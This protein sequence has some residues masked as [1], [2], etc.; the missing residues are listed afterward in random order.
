MKEALL[1]LALAVLAVTLLF[2]AAIYQNGWSRS[3]IED[4]LGPLESRPILPFKPLLESDRYH[5]FA[6]EI[7]NRAML[8]EFEKCIKEL[9]DIG[10]DT[11]LLSAAGYQDNGASSTIA[12]LHHSAPN[13]ADLEELIGVAKSRGMRVIFMPIV[14]LDNPRGTEWRG[15]ITPTD[16]DRWWSDYREF[17]RYYAEAAEKAGADIFMVGSELNRMETST[18]RWR[19]LI[20]FLRKNYPKLK[21]GYSA[22]WDRYWKVAFWNDLDY[23]GATSYY[24][25]ARKAD[26]APSVDTIVQGWLDYTAEDGSRH[27]YRDKLIE[28]QRTIGKP[29]IFTEVGYYSRLGT[30]CEPWNYCKDPL[31][32]LSMEEQ[33][34]CFKA[35]L[36][37]WTDPKPAGE[38]VGRRSP[39]DIL[40]GVIFWKWNEVAGGPEDGDYTPKGKLAEQVIR[41]YFAE[42]HPGKMSAGL[43]LTKA[44]SATKPDR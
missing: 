34:N 24:E 31:P 44:A 35:F 20:A 23:A 30:A 6:I 15:K 41:D 42:A 16:P 39:A 22:N 40:G 33:A 9:A 5:G 26:T 27:H 43:G 13:Q 14:L 8:G 18:G 3:D 21:L 36:K 28:W 25:L 17:I 2:G 38:G 19:S 32:A 29:V 37:V 1:T 12:M 11:V 4:N 10:A 7:H